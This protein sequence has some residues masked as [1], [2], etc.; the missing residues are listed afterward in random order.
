MYYDNQITNSINKIKTTQEIVNLETCRKARNAAIES[1]NIDS[2]IIDKQQH[3]ADTFNS[4]FLSVADNINISNNAH[5]QNRYNPITAMII[6]PYNPCHK[7]ISQLT[8]N[9]TEN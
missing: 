5:T 4:Y 1:F 2:R 7:Y 9:I 3:I 8:K 6:V